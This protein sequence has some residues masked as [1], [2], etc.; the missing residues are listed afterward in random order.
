MLTQEIRQ[1]IKRIQI[2]TKRMM[3]SAMSG[4]YISAFKGSGLEFHQIR[5]YQAG[6]D[7]RTID[8][9]SSA[10]M[11]KM[12]VKQFI[13]ERDR[14][15][16]LAIDVSGSSAYASTNQLRKD[17]VAEIS[18]SLSFIA[19]ESK[20][21]VGA[22]FFSNVVEKWIPPS[23]G[24]AHSNKILETVYSLKPMS[25][26]TDI[27]AALRF[28]ISLKQRNAV[29]FFISDWIDSTI[30]YSKLLKVAGCEF[31]F[32]G[33]RVLDQCEQEFPDIGLL[34]IED[35]ETGQQTVI[36][37]R[38]HFGRMPDLNRFLQ[39]RIFEQKKLFEKYRIDL[40]DLNLGQSFVRPLVTF[41]HQRIRRQI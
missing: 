22:L 26:Q 16:I 15:I 30:K 25:K 10:K 20:D 13:E 38:V 39:S 9:N 28:L 5:E 12:M 19:A 2:Y 33:I 23:R 6:D 36:D 21:K 31:D 32:I 17:L 11:N 29:V 7:I 37:T 41:F 3:Q 35:P 27:A 34:E 14:T 18:A 40:L 4:D 1:K 24:M 8:W